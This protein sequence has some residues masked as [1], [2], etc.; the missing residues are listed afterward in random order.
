[1]SVPRDRLWEILSRRACQDGGGSDFNINHRN[2]WKLQRHHTYLE[3]QT[4]CPSPLDPL[5]RSQ[6]A[7]LTLGSVL[8][9]SFVAAVRSLSLRSAHLVLLLTQVANKVEITE[10]NGC[11][12][13]QCDGLSAC[14]LVSLLSLT[15]CGPPGRS[16]RRRDHP[17]SLWL[18]RCC[19]TCL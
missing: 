2:G 3:A 8:T 13:N 5:I 11:R 14:Q 19:F 18:P 15:D 16:R 4:L 10:T 17:A 1:M 7:A 12:Q 6:I 9:G